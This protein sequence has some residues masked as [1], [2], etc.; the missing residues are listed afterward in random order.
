MPQP[1]RLPLATFLTCSTSDTNIQRG[2]KLNDY[3]SQT[4]VPLRNPVSIREEN[5]PQRSRGSDPCNVNASQ[6]ITKLSALLPGEFPKQRSREDGFSGLLVGLR[7]TFIGDSPSLRRTG[8]TLATHSRRA[9]RVV[10]G[11]LTGPWQ[12]ARSGKR[13]VP[14]A[15]AEPKNA[16]LLTCFSGI[17]SVRLSYRQ[18]P[19]QLDPSTLSQPTTVK[20]MPP[21]PQP[22]KS[23]PP[24]AMA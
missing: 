23:W 22:T 11:Y 13:A 8:T 5:L 18:S 17:G 14:G 21:P 3:V 1:T 9:I 10:F 2:G 20:L 4:G 6:K 7:E 19:F 24:S 15:D 12:V 16:G